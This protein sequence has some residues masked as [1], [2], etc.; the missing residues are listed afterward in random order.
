[1]VVERFIVLELHIDYLPLNYNSLLK[2]W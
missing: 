1:L 2:R